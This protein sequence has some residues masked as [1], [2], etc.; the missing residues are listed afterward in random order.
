M[1]GVKYEISVAVRFW[2]DASDRLVVYMCTN[3]TDCIEYIA[4]SLG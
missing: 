2:L 4:F 1:K 3:M